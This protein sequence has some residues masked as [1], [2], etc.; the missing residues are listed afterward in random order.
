MAIQT[1]YNIIRDFLVSTIF[2]GTLSNGNVVADNIIGTNLNTS[3][4]EVLTDVSL[5][6]WL[7]TTG[8]IICL[9]LLIVC[10]GLFLRWLFRLTSGLF[11]GK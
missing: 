11:L 9:V 2:G 5:G 10:I 1:L 7:S 6:D 4:F 3:N 8:T